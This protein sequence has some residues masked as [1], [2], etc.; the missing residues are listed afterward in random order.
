MKKI[1]Y[2]FAVALLSVAA[3][4]GEA[5]GVP[6]VQ[7]DNAGPEIKSELPCLIPLIS[8]AKRWTALAKNADGKTVAADLQAAFEE[9]ANASRTCHEAAHKRVVDAQAALAVAASEP[10]V[11]SAEASTKAATSAVPAEAP[12]APGADA[13]VAAPV[14]PVAQ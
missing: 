1:K 2:T 11:E 5:A 8:L 6:P 13:P 12:A 4:R 10:A 14:A 9:L 7:A 3:L